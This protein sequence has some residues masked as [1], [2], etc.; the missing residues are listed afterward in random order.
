LFK[1]SLKMLSVV[2]YQKCLIV[3]CRA[4]GY[5]S[6][7]GCKVKSVKLNNRVAKGGTHEHAH[8]EQDAHERL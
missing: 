7:S 4:V 3:G 2:L 6:K 1:G 8:V 5:S